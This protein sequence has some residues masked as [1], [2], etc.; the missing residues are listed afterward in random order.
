VRRK[1]GFGSGWRG[2]RPATWYTRMHETAWCEPIEHAS[3]SWQLR[4]LMVGRRLSVDR[5]PT[6]RLQ[7]RTK[8]CL[9]ALEFTRS[10]DCRRLS[11]SKRDART[12]VEQPR[13]LRTRNSIKRPIR[14]KC[15]PLARTKHHRSAIPAAT[16]FWGFLRHLSDVVAPLLRVRRAVLRASGSTHALPSGAQDK[17]LD[18]P[19][20]EPTS[21]A[22][23]R[24]AALQH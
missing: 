22:D 3:K 15:R 10:R 4:V 6:S 5:W 8:P 18:A 14:H 16:T 11:R 9:P 7:P 12:F 17:S 19:R 24:R 13:E 1:A 20:S 23:P 2:V 21:R